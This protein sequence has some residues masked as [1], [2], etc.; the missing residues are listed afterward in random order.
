MHGWWAASY[1]VLWALVIVLC[2]LVV[3]LA[4]QIGTL[5]G[6][7]SASASAAD[8]EGPLLGGV[9]DPVEVSDLAGNPVTLGATGKPRL[10]LFVS[11]G[12]GVCE[13]ILPALGAV[14]RSAQVEPLVVTDADPGEAARELE[15]LVGGARVISA[16]EVLHSYRVPATPYAVALDRGGAVRAKGTVGS[17]EQLEDIAGRSAPDRGAGAD[18]S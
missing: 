5:T 18:P 7:R 2:L 16:P 14:G 15:V 4:R 8:D 3:A 17:L 13:Q 11:P 9:L 12:C 1:L 10:L 6:I